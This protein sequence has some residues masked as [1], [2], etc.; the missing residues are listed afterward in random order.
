MSTSLELS[1]TTC[2]H[3]PKMDMEK[4]CS[5]CVLG[6]PCEFHPL[7]VKYNNEPAA[8]WWEEGGFIRSGRE[9]EELVTPGLVKDLQ[10]SALEFFALIEAYVDTRAML[11]PDFREFR[12]F[13]PLETREELLSFFTD[14]TV[15]LE[16]VRYRGG[17]G[18]PVAVE[19]PLA[20]LWDPDWEERMSREKEEK[21]QAERV[22]RAE[23]Q[24]AAKKEQE[25]QER[26]ELARLQAK[27][28]G[29]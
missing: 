18:E 8:F 19:F 11:D 16:T 14:H 9:H 29:G 12:A 24:E 7:H 26:E 15:C 4:Y 5:R 27:Y 6:K 23:Q 2:P 10:R 3:K 13:N 20:D 21:E 22:R 17:S 28:G 1:C 25:R